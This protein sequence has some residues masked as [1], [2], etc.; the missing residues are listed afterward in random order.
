VRNFLASTYKPRLKSR[1]FK[2]PFDFV[3]DGTTN[4]TLKRTKKKLATTLHNFAKKPSE[5]GSKVLSFLDISRK[6]KKD[7]DSSSD[8]EESKL[9]QED[10]SSSEDE[11][12]FPTETERLS[13]ENLAQLPNPLRDAL[14]KLIIHI[15]N[16]KQENDWLKENAALM[17]L[18]EY[19]AYENET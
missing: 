1:L 17:L 10:S 19:I 3:T 5:T 16:F 14:V 2:S 11:H 12:E 4:D 8:S 7:G 6:D 13:Q 18:H 9:N 15:F